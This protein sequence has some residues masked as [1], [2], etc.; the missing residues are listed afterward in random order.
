VTASQRD[1]LAVSR[2]IARLG[3]EDSCLVR[4][5]ALLEMLQQRFLVSGSDNQD[6]F[7]ILQCLVDP[8]KERQIVVDLAGAD[9]I[10]L[11]MQMGG[12]K[13]GRN[14]LLIDGIQPQIKTLARR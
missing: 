8:R 13:I 14:G 12:W 7:A 6:L 11:V 9:G 1:D 10:G 2:V 5:Q 3:V 4:T